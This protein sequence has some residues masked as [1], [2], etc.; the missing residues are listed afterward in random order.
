MIRLNLFATADHFQHYIPLFVYCW[1]K[2]YPQYPMD[3]AVMGELD[4]TSKNALAL[5][6]NVVIRICGDTGY[7]R[8]GGAMIT[9]NVLT[10][11]PVGP[12]TPNTARF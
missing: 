11:I 4:Q 3:I 9:Q 8:D 10:N 1:Q 12:S 5:V 7:D 2:V 6:E